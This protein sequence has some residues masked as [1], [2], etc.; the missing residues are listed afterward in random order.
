VAPFAVVAAVSMPAMALADE[1]TKVQCAEA[2]EKAQALRQQESLQAARTALA[3]CLAT[4]CPGPI[5]QDCAD[6]IAEIDRAIPTLVFDVTDLAG[7]DLTGVA[8][9][10]DGALVTS[11]IG[12]AALPV[13]PGTHQVTFVPRAGAEVTRT[14]VVREAEKARRIDVQLDVPSPVADSGRTQRLVAIVAAST[15][16]AGVIVGSVLG[17]V[18]KST[19]DSAV[20]NDCGGAASHCS[21][22]G[23]SQISS[24]HAQAT[25]S[26]VAFIAGGALIAGGVTLW[27]TA[28][29][30]VEVAPVAGGATMG[31]TGSF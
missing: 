21:A 6:R 5:R 11:S 19:Y 29:H 28:R 30:R 16:V 12:G 27:L 3:T 17:F 7:H 20:T 25:G 15:G 2:N 4:S 1:P 10:V 8:L 31:L 9:R 13:D 23:V 22:T 24:A 18:A 14:I 26:T